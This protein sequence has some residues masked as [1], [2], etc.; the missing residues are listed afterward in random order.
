VRRGFTRCR[1]PQA[2]LDE[3]QSRYLEGCRLFLIA[4]M[5]GSA[6]L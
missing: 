1:L 5:P 2:R 4:C 3:A 6:A